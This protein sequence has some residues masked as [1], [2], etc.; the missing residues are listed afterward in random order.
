MTERVWTLPTPSQPC[1]GVTDENSTQDRI[2]KDCLRLYNS[3]VDRKVPFI[4]ATGPDSKVITWYTCGPTVY[5]V[6]HMGHA[7][8]YLAFDIVRRVLEDYFG[9]TILYVM[10]VTDVDDKIILRARRNYLLAMY[11]SKNEG[12]VRQLLADTKQ[13]IAQAESKQL[14]KLA[15]MLELARVT[16][17]T[18]SSSACAAAKQKEAWEEREAQEK[19]L[20]SKILAA[21]R[22]LEAMPLKDGD[23]SN[24]ITDTAGDYLAEWLDQSQG[25]S[26]TDPAIFRQHAAK[27]EAAFLEDMELLGVRAPTVM[28][29][30]SEYIPEIIHYVEKIVSQGFAYVASEGSV[31]FDTQAFRKAGH[32]Y[33][34]LNPWAVGAVD[35][36]VAGDGNENLKRHPSDFALW[37]AAKPGEPTWDSP[38]GAGRPGW[39]IECSAMA[40]S[41]IGSTIDIHTGGEDLRF[42]HHDNELAQAE[43]FYHDQGCCQW[44]NYFLHSGHLGI[45]GLKMSKSLKNFITIR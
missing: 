1:E 10:N 35:N 22:A 44:V 29:R 43:A 7:R 16:A 20:L 34:K 19:L 21:K 31:Y 39:H 38:W 30:V 42:P 23:A 9:Y 3:L 32:T 2:N 5:D 45:E 41:I 13:A 8:N 28:T 37:K 17:E 24:E 26:V 4:P 18:A 33:G 25:S 40:S 15:Q 14:A 27:Y 12:N 11:L 36:S 6:A